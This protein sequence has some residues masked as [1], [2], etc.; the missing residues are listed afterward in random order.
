MKKWL[1]I[2]GLLI[3]LGVAHATDIMHGE[4]L[5]DLFIYDEAI[6]EVASIGGAAISTCNTIVTNG[7]FASWTSDD[8]DD[9]TFEPAEDANDYVT[10]SSGAVHMVGDGGEYIRLKTDANV[11]SNGVTY[12]WSITITTL[13]EGRLR[14]YQGSGTAITDGVLTTQGTHDG[15]WT[16]TADAQLYVYGHITPNVTN[17][18]FDNVLITVAP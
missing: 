17:L 1:I 18:I 4:S 14:L 9:W 8:P 6:E 2:A 7:C 5:V 12:N 13:T 11:F 10:E 16:A 3:G 15:Q